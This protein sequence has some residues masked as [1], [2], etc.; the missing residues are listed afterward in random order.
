MTD[1]CVGTIILNYNNSDLTILTVDS[2][3][4]SKTCMRNKT[5]LIDNGSEKEDL[6][7]LLSYMESLTIDNSLL[8]IEFIDNKRNLGFSGGNNVGIKRILEDGDITHI[9]LLN[10][11]VIVT[12]YWIDRLIE[13]DVD[14]I[15]PVTNTTGNE[16]TVPINYKVDKNQASIDIVNKLA[17]IWFD[18]R[19]DW[20]IK[21]EGLYFF[22]TIFRRRIVQK[23]GMLDERFFPGSFEDEDYCMRMK[24][25][26]IQ[27]YVHRGVYIHHFGS[28]SFE[29]LDITDR[30]SISNINKRKFEEKWGKE[31]KS[32]K[33]K[34]LLSFYQDVFFVLTSEQKEKYGEVLDLHIKKLQPMV[35]HLADENMKLAALLAQA[36]HELNI[37]KE[38]N[39]FNKTTF[40]IKK[41]LKMFYEKISK[42]FKLLIYMFSKEYFTVVKKMLTQ[43]SIIIVAPY[44][45]EERLKDGYFKRIKAIDDVLDNY[46]KIYITSEKCAHDLIYDYPNDKTVII[47]N[48]N[49]SKRHQIYL[50]LLIFL[51]KKVYFHSILQIRDKIFKIPTV[52]IYLDVHGAVPEEFVLYEDYIHSQLYGDKEAL[53]IKKAKGIICVT[54]SMASHLQKKY[55]CQ[56]KSRK[57]LFPINDGL[58]V[59]DLNNFIKKS[60]PDGKPIVIYA[61]GV[62]KWQKME[63]MQR[64]INELI[65]KAIFNICVP[66]PD[67]FWSTWNYQR[68]MVCLTVESKSYEELCEV[69]KKSHYGFVLRDDIVVNNVAC[70]TKINEYLEHEVIPIV[71]SKSIGDFEEMGM[72]YLTLQDFL[73]GKFFT[74]DER[75]NA[76]KKNKEVLLKY[77]ENCTEGKKKFLEMIN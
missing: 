76:V 70:P 63:L 13:A 10:S 49:H 66:S 73:E 59:R 58:A 77:I 6:N 38:P 16:Q 68:N 33:D 52:K 2:L 3:I 27:M 74:E 65:D 9:C 48:D 22:A 4:K 60:Y 55:E 57:V 36:N 5:Y 32:D 54:N 11:D 61:G 30:I 50:G 8:S 64:T 42:P 44:F 72:K 47:Y 35:S 37:K 19:K 21:S 14:V 24:Q 34:L 46:Y 31:W 29:K 28:G 18:C 1:K 75:I 12:D 69:Y 53:A 43:K 26:N 40:R 7:K 39:V 51:C 20:I 67:D 23:I 25:Q 45:S 41:S 56:L 71:H 15:G 62:Q 17:Q